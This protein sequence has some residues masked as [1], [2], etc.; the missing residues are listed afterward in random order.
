MPT[1]PIILQLEGNDKD[2]IGNR[3]SRDNYLVILQ[4]VC[5]IRF[6][7]MQLDLKPYTQIKIT[8]VSGDTRTLVI[9]GEKKAVY[10]STITQL[11]DRV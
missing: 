3:T 1:V 5:D 9:S 2:E 10:E 6:Q 8:Y 7:A 11:G 4:N